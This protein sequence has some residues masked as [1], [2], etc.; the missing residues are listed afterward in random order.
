MIRKKEGFD[1]TLL[2]S[3]YTIPL[4]LDDSFPVPQFT[5]LSKNV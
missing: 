3:L 4:V 1:D 2:Y 5:H